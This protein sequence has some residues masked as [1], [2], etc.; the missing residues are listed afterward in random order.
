MAS[1]NGLVSYNFESGELFGLHKKILPNS[2]RTCSAGVALRSVSLP[3]I[4]IVYLNVV[5]WV[6]LERIRYNSN[7]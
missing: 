4:P 2:K 6:T 7:E 1:Q 5:L 3:G